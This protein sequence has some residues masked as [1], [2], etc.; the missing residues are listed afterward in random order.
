LNT[1]SKPSSSNGGN[2]YYAFLI[3]LGHSGCALTEG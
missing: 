1:N 3:A 2:A